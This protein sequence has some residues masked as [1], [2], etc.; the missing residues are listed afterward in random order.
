MIQVQDPYVLSIN[1]SKGGI[2]KLPIESVYVKEA[3]LQG[4]GHNHE[5]HYR[6]IQA[7]CFQDIEKLYELNQEGY[8]LKEGM[9]GENLTVKNLNINAL[10]IGTRLKFEGGV[11]VELTKVR[12]PCYVLDAINPRLKEEIV[13]RCGMYAKVLSEGEIKIGERIFI[14]N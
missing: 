2:P 1:I 13:G 8:S 14:K 11:E 6:L 12:K 10:P 4:D 7:V 9:T 3:G 5:K